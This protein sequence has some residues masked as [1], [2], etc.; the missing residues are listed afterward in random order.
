MLPQFPLTRSPNCGPDQIRLR[1]LGGT[2]ALRATLSKV[3]RDVSDQCPFG[4]SA[5]EDLPHFLLHCKGLADLRKEFRSQLELHCTCRERLGEKEHDK[6][7][8]PEFF[9]HLND[10][11]KTV[12]MLGGPVDQRQPE[13]EVDAASREYVRAAYDRRSRLLNGQAE[14]P[15]YQ[16]LTQDQGPGESVSSAPAPRLHPIFACPRAPRASAPHY[17]IFARARPARTA[18]RHASASPGDRY[19]QRIHVRHVGVR[20]PRVVDGQAANTEGSRSDGNKTRES[21]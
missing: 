17:P 2:S 9:R 7:S 1:L 20:S 11:G 6:R 16:D 14:D 18:R 5:V 10:T 19:L 8:C 13:A 21:V 15:L 3:Q 12:F 4:C